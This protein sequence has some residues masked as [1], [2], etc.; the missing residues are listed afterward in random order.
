[1]KVSDPSAI[2]G[3][4]AARIPTALKDK[5]CNWLHSFK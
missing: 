4:Q 2:I 1:M 5:T 3:Q